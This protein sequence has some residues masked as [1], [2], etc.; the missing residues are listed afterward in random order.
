ML[1]YYVAGITSNP[2]Q[3]QNR[4]SHVL[5]W[6]GKTN[7]CRH[8]INLPNTFS[9]C[10][11]HPIP[12]SDGLICFLLLPCPVLSALFASLLSTTCPICQ[13]VARSRTYA[14]S[15]MCRTTQTAYASW[16]TCATH[17]PTLSYAICGGFMQQHGNRIRAGGQTKLPISFPLTARNEV[18]VT[19]SSTSILREQEINAIR[20]RHFH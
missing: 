7:F 19:A 20:L 5:G 11:S 6:G 15:V 16:S 9:K 18:M 2:S 1:N 10:Y 12:L 13:C 8:A 14:W 4:S 3:N 17:W